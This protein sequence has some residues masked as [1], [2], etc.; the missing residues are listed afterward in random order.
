M[1]ALY[2]SREV[3]DMPV[4][5]RMP[6]GSSS[7][8]ISDEEGFVHFDVV[9][10]SAL[11]Q[12]LEWEAASLHWDNDGQTSNIDARILAPAHNA[13]IGIISDIDD[14]ILETGIT[15]SAKAIL[16]NA[17]RILA[18][19]PQDRKIVPGAP[20][21]F[22]SL[23]KPGQVDQRACF[24]ISS[25][26]WN[27]YP[28]LRAYKELRAL[29]SGPLMLRDWGLSRETLG[30]KSHGTHKTAAILQLLSDFPKKRFVLIGDDTQRDLAAFADITQA[31]PDRIAAVFVRRAAAI[32]SAD[33]GRTRSVMEAHDTPFW[34]GADFT[35]AHALL[36]QTGL[37]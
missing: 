37:A 25:S 2:A 7:H 13:Q 20:E 6:D 35:D 18:T 10:N 23:T 24:Y 22:A 33:E 15:G 28:Y 30:S 1:A 26:P 17:H 3:A 5:L 8:A 11:P 19:M 36:A 34:M 12:K 32:A 31:Q 29:P 9:V 16:R 14:T 21:F 27:L 4:S